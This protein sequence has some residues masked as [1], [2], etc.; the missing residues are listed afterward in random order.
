MSKGQTTSC[1]VRLGQLV[2][3]LLFA[4]VL[5]PLGA[6]TLFMRWIEGP[7]EPWNSREWIA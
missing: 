2:G 3:L 6:L 5:I 1:F 4:P 7:P